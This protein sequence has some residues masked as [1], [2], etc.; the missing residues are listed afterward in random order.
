MKKVRAVF[1]VS[2]GVVCSGIGVLSGSDAWIASP[3]VIRGAGGGETIRG[4]VFHDRNR[5]GVRQADEPG[6]PGVLVSNGRDVVRTGPDGSYA[7]T[8]RPDMDLTVIQPLGWRLPTDLRQVPQF[9]YTHKPGGSS[10]ALRYGGLADTGPAP[11][12]V[13]FPL[14][15]R[16]G[17]ATT[18]RAGVIGDS[19]TYSHAE[20]GYVRDST[21]LD[22]VRMGNDKPD[23]LLYLGDVVGDD[24]N[25]LP[26]LLEV[27]AVVGV[28]QFLVVGNHDIDL[29]SETHADSTDSWRRLFGPAYYAFEHGEAVFIVLNNIYFPVGG[30][31]GPTYN[32]LVDEVQVTWL[33]NLL[34]HI[35][36]DRIVVLAHHIP[37]VSF[38][39]ATTD[40]HQT[41]NVLDI[42]QL[43][44]GRPALSLSGHTHTIEN[45]APGQ[46]FAGWEENTGIQALP[47]R[48]I[49][50]GAASGS[51]FQGD[52]D[53]HGVPMALQRLG[54]PKGFLLLDF[55]GAAYRES[56]RGAGFGS[57]TV[58]WLGLNTPPFRHWFD[59]IDAWRKA[60][61]ED[62]DPVPP[63]SINDLPDTKLLTSEDLREGVYLTANIW[64]GCSQ[65]EVRVIL[66]G[67][68]TLQLERTQE[69][70]GEPARI[71]AE[72][73]DPFATQRQLS[74]AR[75][76]LQ[77]QLGDERNQG[78]EVFRGSS[79]GPAPPQPMRA[80]ADR[81]M[82]LWRVRLP[83]G[84]A[85]GVHVAT[86]ISRDRH[87]RENRETLIFEVR[88]ERPDFRFD[89]ETWFGD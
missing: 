12:R 48:H 75:Y 51:W 60:R 21:V 22:L 38:V 37:F 3:E 44:V 19:Q 36:K 45:H 76:A 11:E 65:T 74:V 72:W 80:V 81:N 83:E 70:R 24:L 59:A 86:V 67:H 14:I 8:V 52:F 23:F 13:N 29:D 66:P 69:G 84:L 6:I 62:R 17:Y 82:H 16:S 53:Y 73:A 32:G 42:Y 2:L 30:A 89:R 28:P 10:Q 55:E 88:E 68:G 87:G 61:S 34:R 20:V 63:Y 79:F 26:R 71:G 40:R 64:I 5:D 78:F 35:P 54:A 33:A 77:S 15:P 58:K 31:R 7:L 57:D 4:V 41:D 39:D 9:S 18:F 25:L 56:Y 46:S 1:I 43:V 49:V 47:F 50:A 85:A 27:G